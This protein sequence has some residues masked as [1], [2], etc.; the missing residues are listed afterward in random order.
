MTS[1]QFASIFALYFTFNNF[2][3]YYRRWTLMKT[4]FLSLS[5][6]LSISAVMF[7]LYDTDGNGVLDKIETD[8]IVNQMM[9]V[10]EYLGWDVSELRPVRLNFFFLATIFAQILFF[11]NVM[12][13][14]SSC[15]ETREKKLSISLCVR[16]YITHSSIVWHFSFS[17][18]ASH[19]NI[20]I[21]D[22]ARYDDGNRLRWR[23]FGVARWM[24]ARWIDN[25]TIVSIT[26]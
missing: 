25:H 19:I 18:V 21:S 4:F 14:S 10:A 23:W 1:F 12:T 22:F 26:R 17:A 15:Q 2:G 24:E 16:Y 20:W 13:F 8:A 7:R 5:L 3:F 9:S 6:F 11:V